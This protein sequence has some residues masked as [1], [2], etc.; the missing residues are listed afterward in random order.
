[1]SQKVYT[2]RKPFAFER[3]ARMMRDSEAQQKFNEMVEFLGKR[4]EG[5]V[6]GLGF[7]FS[8]DANPETDRLLGES[9]DK[10]ERMW[11]RTGLED[12]TDRDVEL[13]TWRADVRTEKIGEQEPQYRL[14]ISKVVIGERMLEWEML[15]IGQQVALEEMRSNN[16]GAHFLLAGVHEDLVEV[17]CLQS[18]VATPE[19]FKMGAKVWA[20]KGGKINMGLM[21]L[22]WRVMVDPYR[23]EITSS[24]IDG[25]DEP[26]SEVTY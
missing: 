2:G 26:P 16:P 1:M 19:Q 17:L 18:L 25:V 15:D 5:L 14:H 13:T 8:V 9:V 6:E 3:I 12:E 10:S 21:H 23:R 20:E 11:F 7:S 4:P 24:Y 22:A